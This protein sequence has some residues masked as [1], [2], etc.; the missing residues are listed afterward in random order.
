MN[1]IIE[2]IDAEI[3]RLQA[4]RGL[5]AV[6]TTGRKGG[7]PGTRKKSAATGRGWPRRRRLVGRGRSRGSD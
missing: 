4:A 2:E 7:K 1:R 5:L 3:E 6:E